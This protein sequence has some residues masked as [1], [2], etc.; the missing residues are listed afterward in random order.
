MSERESVVDAELARKLDA[1]LP[2]NGFSKWVFRIVTVLVPI[3][4]VALFVL[5]G[6]VNNHTA[7]INM[8]S[9]TLKD[10]NAAMAATVKDNNAAVALAIKDVV[11]S[12]DK[13][14]NSGTAG[15]GIERVERQALAERVGRAE[16]TVNTVNQTLLQMNS[17]L[18]GIEGSQIRTET[19]L[20][21]HMDAPSPNGR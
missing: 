4:I 12:L 13:L 15:L 14:N 18:S 2:L 20:K 10:A 16:Q 7:Q 1:A 19:M 6:T 9:T 3:G 17:R 11:S 21:A 8:L 5:W